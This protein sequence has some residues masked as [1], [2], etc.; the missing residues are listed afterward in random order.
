MAR[1][2][3]SG[4]ASGTGTTKSSSNLD[5]RREALRERAGAAAAAGA[6]VSS[7]DEQLDATALAHRDNE[8]SLRAALDRVAGL[9]KAIK[10][11][12]KQR[13]K[14]RA[15]R[16]AARRADAKA[17]QRAAAA[18][19]RYDRAVLAGMVRREKERDL[20]K[21]DR[22]AAGEPSSAAKEAAKETVAVRKS[23]AAVK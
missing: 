10:A 23:P 7:L 4:A 19:A 5:R 20:S 14:L 1:S 22:P 8:A 16:K 11:A 15:A 6:K 3:T 13:D 18:E 21:H 12:E 2:T 9:K 17:R